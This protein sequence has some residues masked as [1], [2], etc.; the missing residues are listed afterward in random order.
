VADKLDS[1]PSR[2]A[3]I[4]PATGAVLNDF[5][6]GA[7]FTVNYGDLAVSAASG[8][9][10]LVSSDHAFIREL[11]PTGAFVQDIPLPAGVSNVSGL[12]I[13]DGRGEGWLSG[14]GGDVYRIGPGA[15]T[16]TTTTT[17]TST[18]TLATTT[19]STSLATTTSSSTTTTV[20]ST[21]STTTTTAPP[22]ACEL[23]DGKKLLLK[24]K[25]GSAKR[26]IGMLSA[27]ADLTLG[28][29]NGTE[30]DPVL[31]GGT[32]RVVSTAGDAFDDTYELPAD[33]WS[34]KKEEG[35][36]LGYKFRPTAPIKSVT[37]QP[38]KRLKI[39]ANGT[40]L[41]HTLATNPDPVDI[42][43]TLGAHCYCLRF[44]GDV[45]FKADKKLLA[46]DAQ[47]PTVCGAAPE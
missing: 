42:V 33:R 6:P 34:Y 14:T 16:T 25:T 10:Y 19:T 24:A 4:D 28:A 31:H 17:S 35:Q 23:L 9:L 40:G 15:T 21:S 7:D 29:G 39:V 38:G 18:T 8:N 36:N 26:G 13:D 22:A 11:T 32:L 1:T 46:K 43:V 45:A 20:T 5:G 12:G 41:G 2:I 44:G 47:A 3:E 37:V 30:D 27:D